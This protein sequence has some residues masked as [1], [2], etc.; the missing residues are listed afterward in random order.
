MSA[1]EQMLAKAFGIN[2]T[3]L[4]DMVD[5]MRNGLS[6]MIENQNEILSRQDDI[7]EIL[8]GKEDV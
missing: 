2:I 6:T 4:K 7:L 3:E 5:G 8:K 1:M